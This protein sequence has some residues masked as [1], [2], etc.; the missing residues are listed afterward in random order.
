MPKVYLTGLQQS[1][2][3]YYNTDNSLMKKT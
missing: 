2:W 1:S 3:L